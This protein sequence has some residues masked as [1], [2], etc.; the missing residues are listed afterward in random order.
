MAN[1]LGRLLDRAA[2]A[3]STTH[4]DLAAELTKAADRLHQPADPFDALTGDDQVDA[5]RTFGYVHLPGFLGSDEVAAL[6]DEFDDAMRAA[7]GNRYEQR[8]RKHGLY[9]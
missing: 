3:L 9:V 5:F 8:Q 7:V 6:S 2:G 4:P 1:D